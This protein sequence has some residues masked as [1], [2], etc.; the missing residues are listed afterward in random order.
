MPV[1]VRDALY[2]LAVAVVQNDDGFDS[3]EQAYFSIATDCAAM[4]ADTIGDHRFVGADIQEN[5]DFMFAPETVVSP[6]P[7]TN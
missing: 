2:A 1:N 3:L 6:T 7:A 4:Y 5:L